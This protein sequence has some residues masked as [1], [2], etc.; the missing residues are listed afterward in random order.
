MRK[1]HNMRTA[2]FT[3]VAV[4]IVLLVLH[5]ITT[6]RHLHD[7]KTAPSIVTSHKSRAKS[8]L[9]DASPS[10][11]HGQ[12]DSA[13]LRGVVE[14]VIDS[15]LSTL[16]KRLQDAV[17]LKMDSAES[18]IKKRIT[19]AI[20]EGLVGVNKNKLVKGHLYDAQDP[21]MPTRSQASSVV[22]NPDPLDVNVEVVEPF[23][24]FRPVGRVPSRL[25]HTPVSQLQRKPVIN[26]V[27]DPNATVRR[28]K[29][30]SATTFICAGRTW[31]PEIEGHQS[32][33]GAAC[34]FRGMC[35]APGRGLP[36]DHAKH[37]GHYDW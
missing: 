20:A 27:R 28:T 33:T 2:T 25:R 36:P 13:A 6:Q 37:R 16:E 9:A 34:Y 10:P 3:V 26:A 17:E 22:D 24:E 11:G 19:D 15:R 31:D 18:R 4:G 14:G 8:E 5:S 32:T 21:T 23:A 7:R 12:S 35:V 1:A 30:L 29:S